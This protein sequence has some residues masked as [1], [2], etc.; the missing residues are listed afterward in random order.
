MGVILCSFFHFQAI[1]Q[2]EDDWCA[3]SDS[4]TSVILPEDYLNAAGLQQ[5]TLPVVVNVFYWQINLPDG[6][7]ADYVFEGGYRGGEAGPDT[8][9]RS[10][11]KLN[12]EYEASNIFFKYTGMDS[13]NSPVIEDDPD[14]YYNLSG[15]DVA[16]QDSMFT[17]ARD[18][19]YWVDNAINIYVSYSTSGFSGASNGIIATELAVN[20]TSIDNNIIV[21]E[22]GHALGLRHTHNGFLDG[23]N[24]CEHV[25]RNVTD[26][27]Y[28]ADVEGDL[29]TD[30]AAVPDFRREYCA[31]NT[32]T[33][34]EFQECRA[35]TPNNFYNLDP[36]TCTYIGENKDCQDTFFEIFESD[37]RNIM[38]YSL[39][40]CIDSY[41]PEQGLL[42]R[43]NL[44]VADGELE[45]VV[46]TIRS[47]YE[48]WKGEYYFAGPAQ[49]DPIYFPHFQPGFDYHF[50]ACE[51]D[52][53]VPSEY[54]DVDF[55]YS[56][57]P[58]LNHSKYSFSVPLHPD[59]TAIIIDQIDDS[60]PRKCYNNYNR[61]PTGGKVTRFNDGAFTTNITETPKDSLGIND[62]NLIQNL[63][64]G[65][66]K[67]E[68]TLEGG[69][70]EEEVILKNN[71]D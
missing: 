38:A 12:L 66:Y 49:T 41:T 29:V 65:L 51:G 1:A 8:V 60:Q 44:S 61:T 63:Q 67:I 22:V 70:M 34:E 24:S 57:T 42:M 17:W 46:G 5:S 62:P 9:M 54:I 18:N 52:Y 68:K 28:N 56:T 37:V 6:S 7:N 31:F 14:G 20:R 47:L 3:T 10:I 58:V 15:V 39:S 55:Q 33:S 71:N 4:E 48:P 2:F 36:D 30:T 53:Q 50:V 35:N 27:L 11:R 21:H 40:S 25:T 45:D 19:G 32:E 16:A 64:P 59:H 23:N 26:P 43:Y 13:F 69:Y